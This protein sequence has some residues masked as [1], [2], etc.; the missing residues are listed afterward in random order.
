MLDVL[1]AG[2][3]PAGAI[4][5]MVLARAGARVLIL[6]R[7]RFPR[8]K[9]CGDT[10]NP[11]ALA[12]LARLGLTGG[13]LE[14]APPLAGMLLSDGRRAIAGRYPDGV[15]GRAITRRALDAWLLERA[16]EAGVK[17]EQE[18][19]V[20]GAIRDDVEGRMRVRGLA[21]DSRIGGAAL[22]LPAQVT[23]AADG[24]RSVLARG[25]GLSSHPRRWRRWA[26]G[27]YASNIAGLGD[28]G[29]M[30]IRRDHYL[31]I[32]PIGGDL[33]NVC[34][35]T[36]PRPG[37]PRPL[38]LIRA[39][40]NQ[41]DALRAR[42]ADARFESPVT[43]LGPLAVDVRAAGVEGLLLAGDAAGFVDPMTGDGLRLAIEGA[44]L[45]ATEALRV[46]EHGDAAGAPARL[47][48]AR[49]ARLGAK[50]RFN[51]SM[52]A[53]VDSHTGLAVAGLAASLVPATVARLVRYAGDA[54]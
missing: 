40:V 46:L 29:E 25:L 6:D 21:V 5:G 41:D 12:A 13:P 20:R 38:D 15:V 39:R 45:A 47:L 32:A 34:L 4:A 3:G 19:I 33:S 8:E 51:R 35:V 11:G 1:I 53:L 28:L 49:R 42:F 24:R 16:L 23:I 10:L 14:D 36:G 44:E 43:V 54:A 48:L 30:H 50:L 26:F 17:V 9:L 18:V 2:A 7:A 37:G 31:G 52:R 27:V 22:R